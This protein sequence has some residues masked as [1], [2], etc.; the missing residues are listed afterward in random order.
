M[1]HPRFRAGDLDTRFVEQL[2]E[3]H[4]AALAKPA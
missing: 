2:L 1:K 4:K 3:E